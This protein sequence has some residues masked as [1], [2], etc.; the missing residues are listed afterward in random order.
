MIPAYMA[1]KEDGTYKFVIEPE[2]EMIDTGD[3]NQD[4][5]ANT[6][7]FTKIV[8][9]FVRKYPDQWFW[10]HQRWKTKKSQVES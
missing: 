3:L 8:E 1:R 4:V 6:Q 5:I 9:D 7:K 10:I 2:V